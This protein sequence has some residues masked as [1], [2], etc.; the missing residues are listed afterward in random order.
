MATLTQWEVNQPSV[1]VTTAT[2]EF[3]DVNAEFLEALQYAISEKLPFPLGDAMESLP[4]YIPT[5][6]AVG[7]EPQKTYLTGTWVTIEFW[8]SY[9]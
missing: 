3:R 9:A 1:G 7:H 4:T 2:A 6:Y 8:M 5:G